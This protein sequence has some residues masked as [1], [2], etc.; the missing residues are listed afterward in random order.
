MNVL[1]KKGRMAPQKYWNQSS[2]GVESDFVI[3]SNCL[4]FFNQILI[5][6]RA[7]PGSLNLSGW[8]SRSGSYFQ[9]E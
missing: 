9:N 7:W 5:I 3:F 2:E 8:G 4:G 1:V 6:T